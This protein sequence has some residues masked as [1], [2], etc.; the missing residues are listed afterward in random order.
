ME[1]QVHGS[2]LYESKPTI[3]GVIYRLLVEKGY[4]NPYT[5]YRELKGK[6]KYY[7]VV[8]MFHV[9]RELGLIRLRE[10]TINVKGSPIPVRYYEMTPGREADSCWLRPWYCYW[11]QKGMTHLLPLSDRLLEGEE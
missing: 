1:G 4:A 5:V 2:L 3:T 6:V 11:K 7:S 9:L 8:R 10:T